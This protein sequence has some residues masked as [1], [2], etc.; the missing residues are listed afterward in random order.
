[1]A[2]DILSSSSTTTTQNK[3]RTMK[4]ALSLRIAIPKVE[5]TRLSLRRFRETDLLQSA[6]P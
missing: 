1:M 5:K 2:L 3:A 4:I 6:I